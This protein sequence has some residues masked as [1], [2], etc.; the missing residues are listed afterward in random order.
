M[1]EGDTIY[2]A[3]AAL[4][5]A[6]LGRPTIGFRAPRLVAPFPSAG[7]TV[8]SVDSHGKHLEIT[9]DDGVVLHT[10]MRMTGSWHL[11][12]PGEK[13]RK[14]S[15]QVRAVIEVPDWTAVCFNAPIVE[16]YRVGDR[17]RPPVAGSLGPDLCRPDA[18]LGECVARL[19]AFPDRDTPIGEVLLDQR[20]ACGVGNVYR[21]EVLF[22]C[23]LSPFAPVGQ[24]DPVTAEALIT[25]SARMLRANLGG[26]ERVTDRRAPGG[27]AVYGRAGKRCI[28]CGT[29]I[30]ASRL[31]EQRRVVWW[32]PTCQPAPGPAGGREHPSG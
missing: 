9:W 12:R 14:P 28:E 29:V 8:A 32:C 18:D 27:L 16:T 11:Y 15:T 23:R 1:P 19:V 26:P 10:H 25:T 21:A 30:E 4:R 3:A 5:T 17:H 31:G 7:A 24:V 22:A 20:V 6:L 2:R 13:W